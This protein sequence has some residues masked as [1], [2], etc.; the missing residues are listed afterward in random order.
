MHSVICQPG[1]SI[2]RAN[3]K[4]N[5]RGLI[6]IDVNAASGMFAPDI[7]IGNVAHEAKLP[8]LSRRASKK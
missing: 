2:L 7:F 1:F 8:E 3:G 5:N 6:G 4:E